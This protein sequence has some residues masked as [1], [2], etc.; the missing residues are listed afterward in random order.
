MGIQAP[1][2]VKYRLIQEAIHLDDNV[3]NISALCKIA[4]V[5]RSGY[6]HG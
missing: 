6:S 5:S 4:C 3:L 2:E 1:A